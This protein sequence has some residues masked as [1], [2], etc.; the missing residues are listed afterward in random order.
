M[1][2]KSCGFTLI[3]LLVVVL[4]IGILAAI[5]LP[6]YQVAVEKTRATNLLAL[7]RSL[8]RAEQVY[9]LANDKYTL[10]ADELDITY[11]GGSTRSG[12]QV[13]LPN[14]KIIV[15][16]DGLLYSNTDYVQL[17]INFTTGKA[18]CWATSDKVSQQVCASMGQKGSTASS[19]S[20]LGGAACQLYN[21][22]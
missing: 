10:D 16:T 4:I 1:K 15:F 21:I 13:T 14:G 2:R 22:D 17:Q 5:A 12:N 9:Y 18:D 11:P 7:L 19:C 20:G 8:V 3:E 6:Q